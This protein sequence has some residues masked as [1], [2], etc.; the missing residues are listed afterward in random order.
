MPGER[1]QVKENKKVSKREPSNVNRDAERFNVRDFQGIRGELKIG[2]EA[3]VAASVH[4]GNGMGPGCPTKIFG[5]AHVYENARLEGNAKIYGSAKVHGNSHLFG[6]CKIYESARIYENAKVYGNHWI[7]G[8]AK[9]HGNVEIGKRGEEIPSNIR[10]CG[11]TDI[12]GELVI[13]GNMKIDGGK[14]CS[15]YKREVKSRDELEKC[16]CKCEG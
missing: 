15:E 8:E 10:I 9:I 2:R 11:N 4:I 12:H 16:K 14:Y 3:M 6:G 5:K 1:R 7:Y 13:S